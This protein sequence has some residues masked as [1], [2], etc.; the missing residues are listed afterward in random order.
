MKGHRP[1]RMA[2]VVRDVLARLIRDEVRDPGVGFVTIS[3]VRL[4]PDLRTARVYVS[5]LGDVRGETLAALERATPFLRRGLARESG[6]RYTPLLRFVWDESL[7]RGAR[8]E[9]LLRDLAPG[10]ADAEAADDDVPTVGGNGDR[11]D[12]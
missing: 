3:D 6:L 2:D 9:G 8:I 12:P 7:A 11:E 10:E 4:S 1:E 5:A